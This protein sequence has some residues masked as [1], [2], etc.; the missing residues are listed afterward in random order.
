MIKGVLLYLIDAATVKAQFLIRFAMQ[1][2]SKTPVHRED[3]KNLNFSHN[4]SLS[5]RSARIKKQRANT[6]LLMEALVKPLRRV[7]ECTLCVGIA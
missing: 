4:R 1:L 7:R 5:F 6:L 3:G 2:G